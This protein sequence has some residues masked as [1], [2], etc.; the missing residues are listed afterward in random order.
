MKFKKKTSING[1][2]IDQIT[3]D[4]SFRG[5]FKDYLIKTDACATPFTLKSTLS[6]FS[7]VVIYVFEWRQTI[8]IKGK[9][10]QNL[11]Q[12]GKTKQQ[13]PIP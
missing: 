7:L 10:V 8:T 3:N 4:V 13:Y 1:K 12:D 6:R 5:S 2:L 11:S 9:L